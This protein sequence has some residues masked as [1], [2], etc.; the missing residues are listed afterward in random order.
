MIIAI[1]IMCGCNYSNK[2]NDDNI[3][4]SYT[5]EEY[6]LPHDVNEINDIQVLDN[7]EIAIAG[8]NKDGNFFNYKLKNGYKK[9]L[10]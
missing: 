4:M 8:I 9:M 7:G 2:N 10:I 6:M 1:T 3:I 5:Q